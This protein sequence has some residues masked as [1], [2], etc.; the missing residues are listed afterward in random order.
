M[1]KRNN[2]NQNY[3]SEMYCVICGNKGVPIPRKIG[4]TREKGHLKK[5]YC[6]HCKK[7]TNH[8]EVRPFGSYTYDNFKEEFELGRFL[9]DGTR[10]ENSDLI[11]CSKIDCDFNKDGRCWNSNYSFDCPYRIRRDD[12]E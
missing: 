4:S 5:L 2:H 8:C 10:Q 9:E 12:N 3:T 1:G 7:V 11:G 6:L